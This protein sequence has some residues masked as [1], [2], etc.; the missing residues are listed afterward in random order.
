MSA[1]GTALSLCAHNEKNFIEQFD[2]VIEYFDKICDLMSRMNLVPEHLAALP[3]PDQVQI[4]AY[5]YLLE[6]AVTTSVAALRLLSANLYVDVYGLIGVLYEIGSL[7]HYGNASRL[8][9]EKLSNLLYGSELPDEEQLTAA[10]RLNDQAL[11]LLEKNNPGLKKIRLEL[12]AFSNHIS[13]KKI[14]MGK[15]TATGFD[16]VSAVIRSSFNNRYHFAGIDLL[17]NN[18]RVILDEYTI[19]NQAYKA[20]SIE[21]LTEVHSLGSGWITRVRPKLQQM[22]SDR[23]R[24]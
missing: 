22:I 15:V 24:P 6:S 16:S 11:Q 3:K 14:V 9:K 21:V 17:F 10:E 2:F 1:I 19:H 12:E 5:L 7:M 8:R 20:V 4:R 18:L 23:V 13:R